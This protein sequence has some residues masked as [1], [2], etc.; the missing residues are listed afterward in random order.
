[1]KISRSFSWTVILIF[2]ALGSMSCREHQYRL[3]TNTPAVQKALN[4]RKARSPQ[5]QA[6][7]AKGLIGENNKGFVE[8]LKPPLQPKEKI[9]VE[10]ENHDRRFIYDTVVKQNQLAPEAL[11]K[12][13]GEFAK[14]RR[15]RAKKGNLI[16]LPSGK[17]VRK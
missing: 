16:Q 6:L 15:D 4:N 9:L 3:Q 5:L 14:T 11:A 2:L 7:K 1:M 8:I 10:A 12:V 17:W 13:E